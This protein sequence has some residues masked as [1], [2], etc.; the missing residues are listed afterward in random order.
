[1]AKRGKKPLG[2]IFGIKNF[3]VNLTKIPPGGESALL[4]THSRQDEMIYVLHG[5]PT[6]VTESGQWIL[7]PGMCAGFPAGGEAHH[8]VNRTSHDV[9]ILEIGD[10]TT[11]DE[12]S[13]P[14]DNLVAILGKNG[15]WNFTDKQGNPY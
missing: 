3:G 13:Y 6:L 15:K 4:H 2:D 10:R 11:G 14:E 8:L 9:L 7:Q 5:E 1:M 12:V